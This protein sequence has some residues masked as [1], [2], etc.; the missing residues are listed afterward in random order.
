ME[1]GIL[2][3]F[4]ENFSKFIKEL[5]DIVNTSKSFQNYV[6]KIAKDSKYVEFSIS[7]EHLFVSWLDSEGFNN[8]KYYY[9]SEEELKMF[10]QNIKQKLIGI[11]Q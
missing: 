2:I 11:N 8:T 10:L 1:N 6:V 4:N 7:E 3:P 9:D 5:F